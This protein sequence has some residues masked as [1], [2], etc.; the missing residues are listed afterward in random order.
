LIVSSGDDSP[1][2]STDTI[3]PRAEGAAVLSQFRFWPLGLKLVL[4]G[5]G[6][7]LQSAEELLAGF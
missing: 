4:P 1:Q 7:L 5:G 3:V 2:L 6:L